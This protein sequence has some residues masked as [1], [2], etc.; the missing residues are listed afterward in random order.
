MC[1]CVWVCVCVCVWVCVYA[2]VCVCVCAYVCVNKCLCLCLCVWISWTRG[3]HILNPETLPDH[4][5]VN[6]TFPTWPKSIKTR[7][8]SRPRAHTTRLPDTKSLCVYGR[9]LLASLELC[10]EPKLALSPQ[11]LMLLNLSTK[12]W[13][14]WVTKLWLFPTRVVCNLKMLLFFLMAMRLSFES[15]WAS[16]QPLYWPDLK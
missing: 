5:M 4:K 3:G 2:C 9:P 15:R 11:V 1:V 16:M 14:R 10:V 12:Y 6:C 13:V 8:K 7:R